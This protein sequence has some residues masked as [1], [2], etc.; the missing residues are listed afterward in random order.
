MTS[1][2]LK[3]LQDQ[4]AKDKIIACVIEL[5]MQY[6]Y[7]GH[8][9]EAKLMMEQV[10]ESIEKESQTYVLAMT[11]LTFLPS[12]LGEFETSRK[13]E[14]EAR[15]IISDY[16][17]FE[18]TIATTL[19]DLSLTHTLFFMGEF[20][21]SQQLSL[22]LL[23]AVLQM[24]FETCL[25]LVYYQLSA[26]SFFL[27][28]WEGGCRYAE[29][30]VDTCERMALSDSRKAWNHLAWAQNY[31]GS[32]QLENAQE[33]LDI[34]IR[35][36][37]G[38]GNRWGLASAQEYQAEIYL[39]E[40]RTRP[41][42]RV[43]E[44][45]LDLIKGYGL[46]VTRA[47][48]ENKHAQVL[49]AENRNQESLSCL[50]SARP[51]LAGAC[52]HLFSN[53]LLSAHVLFNLEQT[54]QSFSHL[55]KA[56][57][58]SRK[59][60]YAGQLIDNRE[61]VIPLYLKAKTEKYPLSSE[62]RDYTEHL[63]HADINS[64]PQKLELS[65]LG[66]FELYIGSRKLDASTWKSSKALMLLKY[67]AANQKQGYLPKDF[68]IELLWPEHDPEKTGSRFNMAMSSLRK[69][70]EPEIAPKAA[71]AY[72]HRKKDTYRIAED[73]CMVDTDLFSSLISKAKKASSGS[74]EAL[75]FYV[76]ACAL[77]KG[78]FL[79]EDLYEDWCI[80][81]RHIFLQQYVDALQ[82]VIQ[83]SDAQ[84]NTE[85]VIA[86]SQ[87]LLD[88][89]PLDE[90]AVLRLMM[91]FSQTGAAS[92]AIAIYETYI[93]HANELDLPACKKITSFFNNLVKI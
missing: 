34:S 93:Y 54:G 80:E 29:K 24:N 52:Y 19:I 27:R 17:E 77:Y 69:T 90:A 33:Q 6:Y 38:P 75:N 46:K 13:H 91:Y 73:L 26:N 5:G 2:A 1:R 82:A 39:R 7:T 48:L 32:G 72:I 55:S 66:K 44:N 64:A 11:F 3:K 45:A 37:E 58:F 47:I 28:E 16:S 79:E 60:S 89:S 9:K 57:A 4:K 62:I 70:L 74:N 83:L 41:A 43:L 68:L 20:E 21:Y 14:R 42:K 40:N 49:L 76:E 36:F 59:F 30:G 81:N 78:P 8:L 10:L 51:D 88:V 92:K 56:L 23:D 84:N 15:K 63:F 53:H 12:I 71:S 61:W 65:L 35:L 25:P 85:Q 86:Y 22:K 87:K 18:K 50:E 67:L 31:L